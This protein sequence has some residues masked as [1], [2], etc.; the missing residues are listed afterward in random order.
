[1]FHDFRSNGSIELIK[2]IS[3]LSLCIILQNFIFIG[4]ELLEINCIKTN[5]QIHKKKTHRNT[6]R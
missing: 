2:K 6:R 1:M 3:Y 4:Q 5:T